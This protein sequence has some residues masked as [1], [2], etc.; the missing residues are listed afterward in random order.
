MLFPFHVPTLAKFG[1]GRVEF[2]ATL[3]NGIGE[4]ADLSPLAPK[5]SK[6]G[7]NKLY[8]LQNSVLVLVNMPF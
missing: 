2:D 5:N 1:L 7:I 4:L 3:A 8:T 6:E